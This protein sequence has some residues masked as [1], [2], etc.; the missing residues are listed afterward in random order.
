MSKKI[1]IFIIIVF[2]L[3]FILV[4]LFK[5]QVEIDNF[6]KKSILENNNLDSIKHS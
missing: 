1:I 2:S 3:V 6:N 5:K 4:I